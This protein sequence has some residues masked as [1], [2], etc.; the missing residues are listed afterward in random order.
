VEEALEEQ[1]VFDGDCLRD[2]ERGAADRHGRGAVCRV[3]AAAKSVVG[4]LGG[5]EEAVG[6]AEGAGVGGLLC[7]MV[8]LP[9]GRGAAA[10]L[11]EGLVAA[12]RGTRVR[13]ASLG[14][15]TRA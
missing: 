4:H 13:S 12:A 7:V 14:V 15:G 10:A 6:G 1:V 8:T 5:D 2:A 9:R 3:Q 11:D